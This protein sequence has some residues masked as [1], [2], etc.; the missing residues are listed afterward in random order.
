MATSA[1]PDPE[2]DAQVRAAIAELLKQARAA[3]GWTQ[4]ELRR[5]LEAELG[6]PVH[7][8]SVSRYERGDA[9][10][11]WGTLDALCRVLSGRKDTLTKALAEALRHR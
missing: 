7:A 1:S 9:M 6:T 10:P 3:Q 11:P 8:M 2:R 4:E 5:R